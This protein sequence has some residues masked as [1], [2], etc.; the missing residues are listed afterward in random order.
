MSDAALTM[1]NESL[2]LGATVPR[3]GA[4]RADG[5]HFVAP[6]PHLARVLVIAAPGVPAIPVSAAVPATISSPSSPFLVIVPFAVRISW[7][8]VLAKGLLR[9]MAG[10]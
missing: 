9:V 3:P 6:P 1:V 2:T 4:A 7:L 5:L 10:V 8:P